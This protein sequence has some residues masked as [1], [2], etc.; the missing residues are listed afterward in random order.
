[1]KSRGYEIFAPSE[2]VINLAINRCSKF[3]EAAAFLKGLDQDFME[4]LIVSCYLQGVSDCAG[5]KK[6]KEGSYEEER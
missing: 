5:L 3:I 6:R 1:M 4:S 2:G